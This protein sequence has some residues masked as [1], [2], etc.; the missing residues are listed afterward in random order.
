MEETGKQLSLNEG[1]SESR[2]SKMVRRI[3]GLAGLLLLIAVIFRAV[4][5]KYFSG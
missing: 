3:I 2:V 1:K 5:A 4:Q